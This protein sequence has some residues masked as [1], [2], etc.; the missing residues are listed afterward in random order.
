MIMVIAAGALMNIRKQE[1]YWETVKKCN[2][3][4][5]EKDEELSEETKSLESKLRLWDNVSGLSGL[6]FMT[7][8][9]GAPLFERA[10]EAGLEALNYE[11]L[12]GDK[13]T[14]GLP[15]LTY[16]FGSMAAWCASSFGKDYYSDL[17]LTELKKQAT[18]ESLE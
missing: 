12:A 14:F 8:L 11:Y 6:L 18:Y 5:E 10:L 16:F 7:S 2:K 17:Y 4:I 3:I 9:V 13:S 1:T 15:T